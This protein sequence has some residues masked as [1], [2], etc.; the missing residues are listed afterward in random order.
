MNTY[1]LYRYLPI[2]LGLI[3]HGTRSSPALLY[4]PNKLQRKSPIGVLFFSDMDRNP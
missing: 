2:R 3:N 4:L 1:L